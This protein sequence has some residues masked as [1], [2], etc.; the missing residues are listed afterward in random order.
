MKVLQTLGSHDGAHEGAFQ[1][2][3]IPAGLF[4]DSTLGKAHLSPPTAVITNEEWKALLDAIHDV[5]PGTM[6]LA[7]AP[8][9]KEPPERSLFELI[10]E[11]IPEPS[12]GWEWTDTWK[13]YICAILEHEGSIDLYHGVLGHGKLAILC[14]NRDI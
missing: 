12:E 7:G 11:A 5:H 14:Y 9:F 10:S 1:Y 8:P 13:A 4:I 6:R 3:R 2:K